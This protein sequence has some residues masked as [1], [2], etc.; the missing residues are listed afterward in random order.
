MESFAREMHFKEYDFQ[1]KQDE[2][3]RCILR[4]NKNI[5]ALKLEY[6]ESKA[7]LK[8]LYDKVSNDKLSE[9]AETFGLMLKLKEE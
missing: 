8:A 3:Q 9:Q 2:Y 1:C 7:S 4:L 6:E 5:D